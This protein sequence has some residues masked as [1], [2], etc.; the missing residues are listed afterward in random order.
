MGYSVGR[1]F[2]HQQNLC[3]VLWASDL[4]SVKPFGHQNVPEH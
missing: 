3:G 2:I 4:C 1:A